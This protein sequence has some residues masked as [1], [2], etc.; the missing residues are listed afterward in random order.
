[1]FAVKMKNFFSM[2]VGSVL[3]LEMPLYETEGIDVSHTS[4]PGF[5][6]THKF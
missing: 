1:M 2:K 5:A 3:E 6:T 4:L